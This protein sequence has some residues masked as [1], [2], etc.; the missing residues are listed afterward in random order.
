SNPTWSE[1]LERFTAYTKKYNSPL[2]SGKYK[3]DPQLGRWVSEQR[4]RYKRDGFNPLQIELL[5]S[6]DFVWNAI[7][8][9]WD[10][11]IILLIRYRDKEGHCNV[12][13]DHKEDGKNLGEWLNRQ[14]QNKK[15]GTLDAIKEKQLEELGIEWNLLKYEWDEKLILLIEYKDREGHCNVPY[16]HKEG[17]KNL[18]IWLGTQRRTKKKGTLDKVKEKQLEELGIE[19]DA[20]KYEWDENI[21]LLIKFKGREGHCNIPSRHKE[22][23]KNLGMWVSTQ[24]KEKKKGTLDTVREKQ[25]EELGI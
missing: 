12:P 14:R 21:I 25:L 20:L 10:E 17:G 19:W 18:G 16:N 11:N 2:V 3:N 15:K 4:R 9:E 8:Y 7:K 5:E 1:M 13:R 24:R 6:N 23:G 22:N